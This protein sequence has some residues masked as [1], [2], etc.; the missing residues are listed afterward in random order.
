MAKYLDIV[1]KVGKFAFPLNAL[2][3]LVGKIRNSELRSK[4]LSLDKNK[5]KRVLFVFVLAY[6]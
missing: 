6:S 4:L 3:L 5:L 2:L 1:K